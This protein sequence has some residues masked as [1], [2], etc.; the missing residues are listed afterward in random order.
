M[1]GLTTAA[2]RRQAS[3]LFDRCMKAGD[4]QV[5]ALTAAIVERHAAR[6]GRAML[7]AAW[8][9][10]HRLALYALTRGAWFSTLD[11]SAPDPERTIAA[12]SRD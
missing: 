11:P 6:H 3:R 7:R 8:R 5:A 10:R 1:T 4:H 9:Q 2:E 12:L